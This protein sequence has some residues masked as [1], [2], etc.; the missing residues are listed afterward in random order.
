MISIMSNAEGVMESSLGWSEAEPQETDAKVPAS[1]NGARER[2]IPAAP[3]LSGRALGLFCPDED[4][5]LISMIGDAWR[6]G[7]VRMR[8]TGEMSL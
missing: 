2:T 4:E 7:A 1:A 6:F 8:G 5:P 3:Y